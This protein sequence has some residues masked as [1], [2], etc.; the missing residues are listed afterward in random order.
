[1]AEPDRSA[2]RKRLTQHVGP[3]LVELHEK[4]TSEPNE[5]RSNHGY[6]ELPATCVGR[7][8]GGREGGREILQSP[9]CIAKLLGKL[10]P[11]VSKCVAVTSAFYS[12]V[13]LT[14]A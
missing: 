12:V 6:A 1:M 13:P 8:E 7:G 4:T 2:G 5:I 9:T 11:N 10:R 3:G 14:L